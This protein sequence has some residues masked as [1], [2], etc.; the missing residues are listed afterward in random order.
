MREIPIAREGIPLILLSLVLSI[1]L[2]LVGTHPFLRILSTFLFLFFL[3]CL[4][5]FR[6]PRRRSKE[7]GDILVSPADGHVTE[8][9][10][11]VEQEF[12][13]GEAVRVAI[14]MSPADVH[15]NR[16]PCEGVVE[17]VEHRRGDFALAFRK[18]IDKEN[19][20]N[21]ILLKCGLEHMLIVQI[22][23]FLARRIICYLAAGTP[24]KQGDVIG[25]IAFGSRVD[26]Y[27]PKGYEIVVRLNEKVKAGQ[28][29]L[30]RR[31]G[32]I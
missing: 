3:F 20:R 26:I 32:Q 23:G 8:I 17:R 4:Y 6:N 11:I 2:F 31:R 22:A 16:A 21:Y 27:V 25:M 1:L 9:N 5:F 7:T 24:V 30:A 10:E 15:V 29:T 19:E 14:F 12:L 28:T 13:K 18:D